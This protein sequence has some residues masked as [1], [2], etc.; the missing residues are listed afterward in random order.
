MQVSIS[1][2][3]F[4][5]SK[6]TTDSL[7]GVTNDAPIGLIDNNSCSLRLPHTRTL[8]IDKLIGIN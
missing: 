6:V 7:T 3:K 8:L 4:S 5:I 1:K 2:F